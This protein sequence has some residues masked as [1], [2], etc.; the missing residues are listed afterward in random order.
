MALPPALARL[1]RIPLAPAGQDQGDGDGGEPVARLA[2]TGNPW[3][4]CAAV[5]A[6]L[7]QAL[8]GPEALSRYPA[9]DG[10]PLRLAIAARHGL[11]PDRIILGNGSSEL[12]ELAAR[13]ML[14]EGGSGVVIRHGCFRHGLAILGAG[15][16]L[17]E[18]AGGPGRSGEEL[19]EGLLA[20][21]QPD[22]RIVFLG[23]PDN[24]TGAL[25]GREGL[26]RL[27]GALRPDILLVVDQAYAEYEDPATYPDAAAHLPERPM[28]LVLH[29]FSKLHGL[30]GLRIGYG[31]G[32]P[33]GLLE[34]LRSP[35]NTS[36]LA[37]V[38]AA[39][40]LQDPAAEA[41]ARLRNQQAR[42]A[43]LQEAAR[44]RCAV[45]GAAGNFLL[46]ES[47]YPAREFSRDLRGR[48]VQVHPLDRHGLPNHVRVA[49][50]TPAE[51]QAFWKAAGALL[52]H[53]GCGRA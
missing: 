28:L 10:G 32:G 12:M 7:L 40:A 25:L 18:S 27:A 16:R 8:A 23:Q 38:A 15:G 13:A 11:A 29:S 42:A 20:S 21:V 24:P 26:A 6:S 35:F 3:G 2:G 14:L 17:L 45:T 50:G 36:C 1:A 44:H 31:L 51:M 33:E 30:A 37:Q 9:A 49:L 46:L 53:P 4:P 52:D 19:A 22:T 5:R 43:F 41:A 34:R 47:I 48:G 39:A